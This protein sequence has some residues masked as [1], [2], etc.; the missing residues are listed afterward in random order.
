MTPRTPRLKSHS[1]YSGKREVRQLKFVAFCDGRENAKISELGKSHGRKGLQ[2]SSSEYS[3]IP[4]VYLFSLSPNGDKFLATIT[5]SEYSE[6]FDFF[7]SQ[8]PRG[9]AFVKRSEMEKSRSISELISERFTN[10]WLRGLKI[11]GDATCFSL[12]AGGR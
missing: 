12:A 6:I 8:A 5:I 11:L 2:N 7:A 9:Q 1:D 10:A 4:I 3:E